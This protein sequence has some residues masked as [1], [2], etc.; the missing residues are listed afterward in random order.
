MT[1]IIALLVVAGVGSLMAGCVVEPVDGVSVG[2]GQGV[3]LHHGG[4]TPGAVALDGAPVV[5]QPAPVIIEHD[6]EHYHDDR[7]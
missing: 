4:D 2:Y 5:A 6:H 3:V 7:Y 1:R